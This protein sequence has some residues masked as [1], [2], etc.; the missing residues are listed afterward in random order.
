MQEVL[1]TIHEGMSISKA[2]TIYGSPRITLND[3]KFGKL[4]LGVKVGPA[5][6]LSTAEPSRIFT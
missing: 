5:P 4:K 6:L 2:S 1:D 3:H